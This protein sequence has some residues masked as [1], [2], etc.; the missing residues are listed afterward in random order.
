[1]PARPS[2]FRPGQQRDARRIDVDRGSSRERG[3]TPAWDRA[4]LAFRRE[5]P[6]CGYC[7]AG[8]FGPARVT[9]CTRVDHLYPQRRFAGVFW[10][11][12]WWVPS[13]DDCDAAKQ[14]LEHGP[15]EGLHR[16]ARLLSRP[17]MGGGGL[18]L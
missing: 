9:P 5:F 14:A 10:E 4:S 12:Q 16:L 1:M 11:Q 7:E 18:N 13:C 17:A 6:L 3:Y 2:A 8:A 15:I